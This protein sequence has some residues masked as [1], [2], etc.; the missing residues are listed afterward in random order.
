MSATV[1]PFHRVYE[2]PWSPGSEAEARFKKILRNCFAAYLVFG[3]LIPLLPVA[4][5]DPTL[6]PEISDRGRA[7]HR[8]AAQA[9][10]GSCTAGG[11]QAGAAGGEG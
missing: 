7:P 4:E 11:T 5:R 1:M 10:A 9:A 3:I 2:L 8:G 6:A